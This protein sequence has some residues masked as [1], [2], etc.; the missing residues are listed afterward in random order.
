MKIL[1]AISICIFI[2]FLV[3][4]CGSSGSD[5]E[6]K[7]GN[8]ECNDRNLICPTDLDAGQCAIDFSRDTSNWAMVVAVNANF[9]SIAGKNLTV[10]AW[11][12]PDAQS[13][14]ATQGIFGRYDSTGALLYIQGGK[15][16]FTLRQRPPAAP[17]S[18]NYTV[19]GTTIMAADNWHHIAGIVVNKAHTHPVTASCSTTVMAETPHLDI[20]VDGTL[21]N[22]AT[23]WDAVNFT[24]PQGAP[25]PESFGGSND[26][27]IAH[28]G[29]LP[30][31]LTP[32]IDG[33]E[34]IYFSQFHGTI[35]EVRLWTTA[36]SAAEIKACKDVELTSDG[37]CALNPNILKGYWK[38]NE[39]EGNYVN[40]WS[41]G[42]S[43][44]V[45]EK[46][47]V[48][49]VEGWVAGAF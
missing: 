31:F 45:I 34:D 2:S 21:E 40:D 14:T 15:A 44:G 8:A 16:K 18:T 19:S 5:G 4:G 30:G 11:I 9:P 29:S 35:D 20:Y 32:Y 22:C 26:V 49:W 12:K 24:E 7:M 47:F 23:T 28:I 13:S 3:I 33:N 38:M 27:N 17:T 42:G 48:P 10:E 1:I 39:C 25:D 37:A 6:S 46:G 41:G 43:A 36:R